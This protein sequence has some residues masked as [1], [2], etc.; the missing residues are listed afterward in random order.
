MSNKTIEEKV[1]HLVDLNNEIIYPEYYSHEGK[2]MWKVNNLFTKFKQEKIVLCSLDEGFEKALDMAT[3][4]ITLRKNE[5]YNK[6][7]DIV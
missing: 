3:K 4:E 6:T 1:R 7:K 5:F 2:V